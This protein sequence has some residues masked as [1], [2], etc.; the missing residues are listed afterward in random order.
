[1]QGAAEQVPATVTDAEE[2]STCYLSLIFGLRG[3]SS[4]KYHFKAVKVYRGKLS[5]PAIS[6]QAATAR[7][8]HTVM[9]AALPSGVIL[10]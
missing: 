9:R 4:L 10:N 1:V 8:K 2:W 3:V 5:Y 7:R 6:R